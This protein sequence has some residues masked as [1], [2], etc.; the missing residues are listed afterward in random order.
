MQNKS[1]T[2]Q[3]QKA[4]CSEWKTEVYCNCWP[5][6]LRWCESN[7]NTCQKHCIKG[8]CGV[9]VRQ[10]LQ[11]RVIFESPSMI[12]GLEIQRTTPELSTRNNK[13][14]HRSMKPQSTGLGKARW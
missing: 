2:F 6:R 3:N 13:L 5:V 12:A 4:H 8:E 14:Y 11:T 10:T 9:C 1:I 7:D